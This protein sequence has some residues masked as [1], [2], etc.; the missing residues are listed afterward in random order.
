MAVVCV[1]IQDPTNLGGILRNSAAFGADLV[2]LSRRCA[3][4]FSRRV[5]RVSMGA[6]LRLSV[7]ES[8][9]LE[10]D[11]RRLRD[12]FGVQLVATVLQEGAESLEKASRPPRL[13]LLFGNEG[14]GLP[15]EM[16]AI[17][18]RRVTVPM[19]SGANS[20]N[21]AVAAGVFLYHFTRVAP[22]V[23]LTACAP[24]AAKDEGQ[25]TKDESQSGTG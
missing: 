6:V 1:D 21:A 11:L 7:A 19:C 9:N 20:L 25:R 13:A 24:P 17:C 5:L 4:P 22:P 12:E 18:Q 16:T 14:H 15:P 2:L 10:G 3:D 8:A 23:F